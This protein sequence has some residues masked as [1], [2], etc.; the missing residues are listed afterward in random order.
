[1]STLALLL[2]VPLLGIS[3]LPAAGHTARRRLRR[4][5]HGRQAALVV[6]LLAALSPVGDG[7]LTG[8]LF[9]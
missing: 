9:E 2:I 4:A 6:L 7:K 1:M 8:K 3:L 5:S